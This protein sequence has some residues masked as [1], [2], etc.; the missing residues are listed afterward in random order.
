MLDREG[1]A[2]LGGVGDASAT[3]MAISK[4]ELSPM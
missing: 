3:C 1:H 4:Q 2:E